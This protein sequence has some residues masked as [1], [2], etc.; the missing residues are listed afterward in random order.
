MEINE[1][2]K[3]LDAN[4]ESLVGILAS[5][6]AEGLTKRINGGWNPLEIAEHLAVTERGIIMM[7]QR[8]SEARS[9]N[10]EL[11]GAEK[12]NKMLVEMRSRK[13]VAPEGLHPKGRYV[14]AAGVTEAL[15]AQR[16]KLKEA[17]S[18]GKVAVDNRTFMH[19]RLGEMTVSDWLNFIVSHAYRHIAQIKDLQR[20]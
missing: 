5:L 6:D 11:F 4:T 14:D 10:T 15:T 9:D 16:L 2:I 8:P 1:Y 20:S 13:V 18:E 7:L 19:P 12:L 3:Q 17:L